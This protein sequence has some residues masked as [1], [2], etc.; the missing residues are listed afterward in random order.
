MTNSMKTTKYLLLIISLF[1]I[2]SCHKK[3]Q[4]NIKIKI[5]KIQNGYFYDIYKNDKL[6]IH[7]TNIPA[8]IYNQKFKNSKQCLKISNLVVKKMNVKNFPTITI[9]ELKNKNIQFKN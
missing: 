9:E 5:S 2:I 8:V 1:S 6:F 4:Q 3:P 7:Q